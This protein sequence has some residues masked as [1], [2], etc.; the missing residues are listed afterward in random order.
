MRTLSVVASAQ[1][2]IVLSQS[3]TGDIFDVYVVLMP[4]YWQIRGA[5]LNYLSVNAFWIN[6][7][8][9]IYNTCFHNRGI[10]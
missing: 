3:R 4:D 5:D 9:Q 10:N 6:A 8:K 2:D 7:R 1:T